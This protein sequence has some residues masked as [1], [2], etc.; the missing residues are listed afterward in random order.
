MFTHPYSY[1][2]LFYFY[3][4]SDECK[5]LIEAQVCMPSANISIC[6]SPMC[7]WNED[8]FSLT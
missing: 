6:Y 7:F 8:G 3:A 4:S 1:L 2:S 5:N